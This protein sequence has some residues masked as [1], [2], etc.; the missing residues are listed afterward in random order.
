MS[1]ATEA[2]SA[3]AIGTKL[4]GA[5]ELRRFLGAGGMGAVY[6]VLGPGG[7]QLA[8]KVLLQKV[9]QGSTASKVVT[10]FEREARLVSS[11]ARAWIDR[12]ATR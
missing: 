5:Y 8:A 9:L 10:R 11:L 6:E 2:I 7:E 12:P 3:P 1:S 4:G